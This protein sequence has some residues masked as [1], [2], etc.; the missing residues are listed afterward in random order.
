MGLRRKDVVA[1]LLAYRTDWCQIDE[2]LVTFLRTFLLRKPE[3]H[4]ARGWGESGS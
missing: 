1:C 2:T 3:A 4:E